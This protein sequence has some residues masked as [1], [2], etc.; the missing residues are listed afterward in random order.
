MATKVKGY[1]K[2]G[3]DNLVLQLERLH[4]ASPSRYTQVE[5]RQPLQSIDGNIERSPKKPKVKRN[6]KHRKSLVFDCGDDIEAVQI[7]SK[8]KRHLHPLTHL[9]EVSSA[10]LDFTDWCRVWTSQCNFIKIAQGSYGAVFRI[11]SKAEPGTFTIG[12]L[13]PLQAK[14]GFGSET[15]EFTSPWDAYN[16]MLLLT[17]LDELP[18]FVQFRKAEILQGVLPAALEVVSAAFDTTKDPDDI[19]TWWTGACSNTLQLW[20]FVEMSDAGID[21]EA[22]LTDDPQDRR[23][24]PHLNEVTV[25]QIR[26]IFWQ[27]ASALALAE[28]RC[29][30]EHRDLHLGNI[31][32]TLPENPEVYSGSALVTDKP[33]L[34]VTI[35]DYTLSRASVPSDVFP[36]YKDLSNDPVLFEGT[37]AL[38]YDVYRDMKTVLKNKWWSYKPFTNVLW[39]H[40]LLCMLLEKQSST[41]SDPEQ[42]VLGRDLVGLRQWMID[43]HGKRTLQDA[44]DVVEYCEKLGQIREK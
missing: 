35:I 8:T 38:Q 5:E 40:H 26:D 17:T 3:R 39:L 14:S 18:G 43:N 2:Q 24:L 6:K 37:G 25:G 13:I 42:I 22:A 21:L 44:E 34:V 7:D 11:E 28:R 12:K 33:S 30:F 16:E 32:L 41:Y 19:S 10:V 31:C 4:V 20:L 27:V 15:E 29:D 1:G 23:G 36:A 9:S